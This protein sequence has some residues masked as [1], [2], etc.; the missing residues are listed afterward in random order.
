MTKPSRFRPVLAL[1]ALAAIPVLH[2]GAQTRMLRAPSVSAA[3]IAFAY[4][5]NIWV[6][7]RAGGVARQLTTF[8]GQTESPKLSPDGRWVAFSAEYGGNMD[9]Y[10]V[11]VEGGEP[12]RLTWHPG[13]DIVQGWTPDGKSIVFSTTR[14]SDAPSGMPR[15]FTV[16]AAGGIE[17][18]MAMPR[19]YQGKISP[20]GKRL[21]YR[22]NN[23]WD[24]ERRNYRGGQ[25]RAIWILDLATYETTSPPWTDSK[26][27]DPVW[28]GDA[29]YFLSDRDGV[30]NVWSYDTKSKKLAQ[31]TKFT[32]FDVKTLDSGAGALVFEQG[33]YVHEL[34]P[35]TEREHVVHITAAGDFPWMRTQW[36]DVGNRVTGLA[37]SPTGKRA[38]VEARGEI[39]TIPAEKGDARNMTNSSASAERDPAWS[40]DGKFVSY[41]SDKSGEYKLMI[42]SQDGITPA[43]EIALP[44]PSHYYTPS[45]SPDGKRIVLSDTH[46]RLWVV[47]VMSGAAKTIGGDPW[48]VPERTLNP[49]WSPDSKWVAYSKRLPSLYHAIF[50]YN[51]ETGETKQ[52][53]DGLADATWPAWDGSGKYLWFLASTNFALSSQWLDMSSYEHQPVRA[54]YM[55]VLSK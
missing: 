27:M 43:R 16:P 41:F 35:K 19:A 7:D 50:A 32:D 10:V 47:D 13:P 30:S 17:E 20:D 1:A 28:V 15:F 40:P 4:A 23:S 55:A 52:I 31:V 37:L 48:L 11:A 21:A 34:D 39:F 18:P 3:H 14:A 29:V 49:S 36:K 54:L 46:L 26:D 22:M 45:W 44:E 6:V 5:N 24:E 12:R 51:V 33:G 8:Q 25:N 2:A 53:T 42:E 38:A 9:A